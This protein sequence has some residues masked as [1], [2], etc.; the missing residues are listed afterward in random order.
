MPVL[1]RRRVRRAA[2]EF[3][4]QKKYFTFLYLNIVH[5]VPPPFNLPWILT[6]L[7]Q[8]YFGEPHDAAD[9]V[10][11]EDVPAL[12]RS[13][14][15]SLSTTTAG[16][17]T[18]RGLN[19]EGTM[20]MEAVRWPTPHPHALPLC[21]ARGRPLT[22]APHSP[23]GAR[24]QFLKSKAEAE[25]ASMAGLV[26]ETN[27]SMHEMKHLEAVQ[28]DALKD[29]QRSVK[30]IVDELK[31]VKEAKSPVLAEMKEANTLMA[32]KLDELARQVAGLAAAAQSGGR[33]EE[34]PAPAGG[35]TVET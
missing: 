33:F 11:E 25:A 31:Q 28:L 17:T 16:F 21:V 30:Q 8:H 4:F 10:E 3:R 20:Y 2:A 22:D 27:S 1:T 13:G 34:S 29:M 18:T 12:V 9:T 5:V 32:S 23:L 14:T 35:G 6:E 19:G 15:R 24:P 26:E 7:H